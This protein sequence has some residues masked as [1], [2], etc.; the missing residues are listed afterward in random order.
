MAKKDDEARWGDYVLTLSGDLLIV[1]YIQTLEEIEAGEREE[2]ALDEE[3][4]R[5]LEMLIS[6]YGNGYRYGRY[7][8]LILPEGEL[9]SHHVSRLK[10]I[11]K[12]QFIGT[13]TKW[14]GAYGRN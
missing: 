6:A 2:G 9:G 12:H 8:S 4:G 13:L 7:Y 11:T 1:G 3:V 14:Q 5:T 10:R